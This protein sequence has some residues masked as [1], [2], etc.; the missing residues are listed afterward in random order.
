MGRL[1]VVVDGMFGSC[2]KGHVT[3]WL[4][5]PEQNPGQSV[6]CVRPGAHQAGHS[7][8]GLDG[9]LWALRQV[10]IAAVINKEAL[11]YIAAGS[12]VSPETLLDEVTRLDAAGFHVS[13]RLIIDVAATWLTDDHIAQESADGMKSGSTKK[14]VG[15]ARA[16]RIWRK[17]KT[18]IECPQ[19]PRKW[20]GF[21]TGNQL[22]NL[23]KSNF[24]VVVEGVQGYGLGVHTKYYPY[25]TSGDCR[26]IDFLAQC[27]I[28]PWA[29]A[30]PEPEIWV[31][32]RPHPIRIAGNSGPLKDE[33]TWEELGLPE[34]KTTVTKKTRRVGA[35]DSDLVHDAV[36][37]NGGN[38]KIAFAMADQVCPYIARGTGKSEFKLGSSLTD[39]ITKIENAAGDGSQV[40]WVGTGPNTSLWREPRRATVPK[41]V[42]VLD[43]NGDFIGFKEVQVPA[44]VVGALEK[45]WMDISTMDYQMVGPKALTYGSN[46]LEQIGHKIAQLQ[47]RTVDSAEAQ[48]L[49]CWF[50]AVSKVERWTDAVMR[51]D[52]PALDTL[53][54]GE[55]YHKMARRIRDVGSWPGE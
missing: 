22:M 53:T 29:K 48:E 42:N 6:A 33:T 13:S 14:G 9:K 3:A 26:A 39:W 25:T 27:G 31:V 37:A 45:W 23:A 20:L 50:Y 18:I 10:P 30:M 36:A 21:N 19:I 1:S 41:V 12:E 54:D 51:G 2:G 35:W 46:S 44:P 17:A 43:H 52:R 24:H 49:A 7:M 47:G 32:I 5:S 40:L 34:E 8:I 38:V 16:D 28:S 4:T 15:A 55:I 11:L